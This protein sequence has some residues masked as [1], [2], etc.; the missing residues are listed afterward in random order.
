M[1]T[2][3]RISRMAGRSPRP[4]AVQQQ[5]QPEDERIV[6]QSHQPIGY[7]NICRQ[8]RGHHIREAGEDE[9]GRRA[10][11][12]SISLSPTVAALAGNLS[13]TDSSGDNIVPF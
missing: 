3:T 12:P 2:R 8:T 9:G 13:D 11:R 10:K 4:R 7:T 6:N 5:Q 1:M